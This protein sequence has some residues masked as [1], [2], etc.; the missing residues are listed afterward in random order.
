VR[1][2]VDE[3]VKLL[4]KNQEQ[5][6]GWAHGPGGP[7][8][9]GYLE[10][11]ILSNWS[12]M[13]V[14]CARFCG[15]ETD[16]KPIDKALDWIEQT[17]SGDGG[18]G[19]S[20]R[21]G[22]KGFGEAGRTS[23]AIVAWSLLGARGRPFFDKMAGF[24]RGHVK[25]LESGHVS[26]CMHLLTGAL[27]SWHL[28]PRDFQDYMD[29]YRLSFMA[30]RRPDGSFAPTP[31]HESQALHSNTDA[32]VGPCWVTATYVL[33]LSLPNEKVPVLLGKVAPEK[34]AKGKDAP[35]RT[36]TGTGR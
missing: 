30:A 27:A 32:Q 1:A 26:P 4:V 19:Y 15:V 2:K 25:T 10:L 21:E 7:N 12:L 20:P 23:G 11:E 33:I 13:G 18:V 35:E 6:G 14:G 17:S 24:Y 31:T 34:G 5:S 36:A 3:V 8:A 9:L 22:Q 29:A 28:G 16:A